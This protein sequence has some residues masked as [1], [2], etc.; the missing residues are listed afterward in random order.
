MERQAANALEIAKWLRSNKH[1]KKVYYP[2]FE[3]YP[4]HDILK[5]ES[6]GFGSMITFEVESREL[7]LY[8][9]ENVKLVQ[10]AESLGGVESL[11]TY[12]ITQTHADV[13]K[14]ILEKN[15][16]TPSVLRLSVGIENVQDLI[17]DFENAIIELHSGNDG[18]YV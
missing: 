10:F 15:G 3:D 14:D 17:K 7:A 8:I 9:L 18:A 16:I 13:P 1:V 11:I 5:E 2:G 4:G 6:T 12:P